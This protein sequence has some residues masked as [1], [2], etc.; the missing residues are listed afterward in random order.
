MTQQ[1]LADAIN[2][3]RTTIAK[4]E[5]GRRISDKMLAKI[6]AALFTTPLDLLNIQ[7]FS[8]ISNEEAMKVYNITHHYYDE[9]LDAYN[10][11][12]LSL[13]KNKTSNDTLSLEANVIANYIKAYNF[14]FDEFSALLEYAESIV[15]KREEE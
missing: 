1:D 10:N 9:S 11:T 15:E 4:I 14:S 7:D 2:T 13:L 5:N 6:A 3:D 12:L 8:S